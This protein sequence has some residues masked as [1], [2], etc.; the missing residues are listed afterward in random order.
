MCRATF[1]FIAT[2]ALF[3]LNGGALGAEASTT[4]PAT[5]KRF[6]PLQV[7]P[8]FKATLFACDPLVEYPSVI[9]QGP[10]AR[11]VFVA[12]DYVTGLGVEIVRRDEVR[13][14][15]DSD[16]D[17]YADKS[18][19]YAA[20]FNSIQGLAHH[21]GTVFVMHAP[22]LTSLR[23]TNGDGVADERRDLLSGLGLTPEENDTRLHCANGVTP[24][25]D[26]WL[27]LALGDHGCD[28]PRPEGDRLVLHGGGILRCRTDGRDLHVFATGLRNIYDVALDDELN[29][30]VR[31]N[32]ND[33]GSYK[34]RVCRSFFGADH[35]Y[36]YLYYERPDEAL[37]PLLSLG[38]GS[39]A[40]GVCYLET[41]F[42]EEYRGNLF[43]CEWGRALVRYK[44]VRV[45]TSFVPMNEIEFATGAA[46]DP[47]GFKPTDVIVDR[48]GSLLVSDWGDG[49]RPKR[50]RGRIY[51]IEFVQ[52]NT[53]KVEMDPDTRERIH[54]RT[55]FE[56]S[57]NSKSASEKLRSGTL[58]PHGRMRALWIVA[59]QGGPEAVP[60]LLE[61]ARHDSDDRVRAQAV[62]AI[63]DLADPVIAQHRLD[64]G[65][66]DA[67]L[68]ANLAELG[69]TARE[70]LRMEVIIALGRLRWAETAHW[71]KQIFLHPDEPALL[72]AAMQALR[73]S[74]NWPAVFTLLD[75]PPHVVVFDVAIAAIA[76]QFDPA[77]VDELQKRLQSGPSFSYREHYADLLTRICH[78]P[79]PWVYWEYR[80][81]PRPANTVS[82]ER[83]AAIEDS[84]N[85]LLED[86]SPHVRRVTLH[87][88]QREQISPKLETLSRRLQDERDHEIASA[89]IES[90]RDHPPASIRDLLEKLI[91]KPDSPERGAM[92]D[93]F[94]TG[95]DAASAGRLLDLAKALE[96]GSVL[97]DA[98]R[99]LGDHPTLPSRE[100]LREKLESPLREVRT[101]A[102]E[103]IAGVKDREAKDAVIKLLEDAEASVRKSAAY[104]AGRIEAAEAVEPLLLLARDSD[105]QVRRECL[106]ALRRLR[107]PRVVP[108]ALG[109]LKDGVC[110]TAA[111]ECLA[112][113]GGP[114]NLDA[115]CAMMSAAPTPDIAHA[116]ALVFF[117]WQQQE[118]EPALRTRIHEAISRLHG[119]SGTLL[120][121]RVSP[122][123]DAPDES[124]IVDETLQSNE[125]RW[126]L[127][128]ATGTESRLE[129]GSGGGDHPA[130]ARFASA[131]IL[132]PE[133]VDVQ[134][135]TS[136]A[137][138]LRIWVNG[139]SLFQ[140]DP[141]KGFVPDSERFQTKLQA[142]IN[143]VLVRVPAQEGARFHLRFRHKSSDAG[144]ERLAQ[145]AL[146]TPGNVQMGRELF[147]NAEKSQCL[148]C[149]RLGDQGGRI[150]PDLTGAGSR[151][152]RVYLV[153]AIL[154][155]SRNIAPGFETMIVQLK[156]G[157]MFSGVRVSETEGSLVLGNLLDPT[158][159]QTITKSVI[160]KT[161]PM[162][163]SVMP[164]GLE[165][166]LTRQEFV[167]LIA[168]LMAQ[169]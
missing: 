64:A 24:G 35:G 92:L 23:D 4:G 78:K 141:P 48:D 119:T 155:P 40:G 150:G 55:L 113:L 135:L 166:S 29:V 96:D 86:P 93:L 6:P 120:C 77:I 3:C 106:V 83:T 167:D 88:M 56:G 147:M 108:V 125:E 110:R 10:R 164:M 15:E 70:H 85:R 38:L 151:F 39:S 157:R 130:A 7:P 41:A 144:H 116:L 9:A 143:R 112:E 25:H 65:R 98:L 115:V 49:Q 44:R 60:Q 100:L 37:P 133:P 27:Y 90:L 138:A 82:W 32:E 159:Q 58:S 76:G 73:R 63:G 132:V 95:L 18:T 57:E 140:G 109:F 42:P 122:P 148:K 123:V 61:L 129:L 158:A 142:G 99:R 139:R 154:E 91:R 30:F 152:T 46:N 51:R 31:D 34:N 71:L 11:S 134:F 107:E 131:E 75:K 17:G 2:L 81:G 5:E 74:Q 169:K 163:V 43:F 54:A 105:A 153:E 69:M 101:A 168:F 102:L 121:W 22:F 137:G 52:G 161:L 103:G 14:V 36:P 12:H 79:G 118:K 80:P 1:N 68:A 149:H 165:K 33:G 47:Y 67:T 160:D 53:G 20:G 145:L 126:P 28:V 136:S 72:H 124:K 84:L 21:D 87:R 8:G 128:L 104:A 111:L 13:L 50:G 127:R 156:D 19:V 114:A 62:R 66:G 59:Q 94:A 26:G 146:T 162:P 89:I 97:A 117:R 45:G 16:A